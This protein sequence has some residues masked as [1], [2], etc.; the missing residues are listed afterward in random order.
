MHFNIV[1]IFP[2]FFGSPLDCGL[3]AKARS[4]E[5]LSFSFYNPRD[6]SRDKHRNVDDR[7][8]G[9][10]AGMVMAL[11]P[12]IRALEDIPSIGKVI[13][14]TPQGQKFDQQKAREY[15]NYNSLTLL[16][17]RYEGIDARL[18]EIIKA[19]PLSLG[20]FVLNGGESAALCFLESV[21]RLIP[22]FMRSEVSVQEESF[23]EGLLEYPHYTRPE[24]FRGHR[25]PEILLSGNHARVDAWRR[26]QALLNTLQNRPELLEKANL[27]TW[28]HEFLRQQYRKRYARNLYLALLHYP[29]L[30]KKNQITTVSLTNLDIHD[31]VRV[32]CSYELGEY[33]IVTPVKDQQ[34][35]GQKLIGHWREGYGRQANPARSRALEKVRIVGELQEAIHAIQAKTGKKPYIYATSAQCERY[36]H[37]SKLRELLQEHPVLLLLGTG[38]GLAREVIANAYALIRPIRFW[39]YY[40]HLSVRSAAAIL[41]DRILGDLY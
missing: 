36:E 32:C 27:K 15:S 14:F 10:G 6:Y 38:S 13:L 24:Y 17:G 7:P 19:D 16:C 26:Q 11:D 40:N 30:N 25:V 23:A 37:E 29:V 22:E 5:I 34:Y 3:L 21:S 31:I 2:E 12:L 39:E 28:D 9:G 1:S 8:Y 18:G 4:R 41:V 20:D 33:Y 35:L